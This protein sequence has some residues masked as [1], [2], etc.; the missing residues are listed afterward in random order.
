MAFPAKEYEKLHSL[1]Q[2]WGVSQ[3]DI[4]YAIESGILKTCIWLPLRYVER[5]VIKSRKFIHE[6]YEHQ[7]GFVGV[8]MEDCKNYAVKDALAYAFLNQ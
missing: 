1:Q 6:I 4:L 5:L 3:D 8:R 2:R 7:E